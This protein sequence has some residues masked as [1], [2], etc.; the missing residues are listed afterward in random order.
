MDKK[1]RV[2][3]KEN[4]RKYR[5]PSILVGVAFSFSL[6][7]T[8]FIA[9]FNPLI[10]F[11]LVPLLLLP[12]MFA[13]ILLHLGLTYGR[14]ITLKDFAFHFKKYFKSPNSTSFD[15]FKTVAKSFIFYII[16][17][18]IFTFVAYFVCSYIDKENTMKALEIYY[19]F[20]MNDL[21]GDLIIQLGDSYEMFHLFE[22][23]INI[24][25]ITLTNLYIFYKFTLDFLSVYLRLSYPLAHSNFLNA[26]FKLTFSKHKKNILKDFFSL[27]WLYFLLI[28]VG[29]IAG[30]TFALHLSNSITWVCYVSSIFAII[31]SSFYASNIFMNM[32]AIYQKY[33]N[34]FNV[35]SVF[36]TNAYLKRIQNTVELENEE[37]ENLRKL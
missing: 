15:F 24:P 4:R 31:F 29:Y 23:I 37:A 36:V 2:L 8:I 16:F 20:L 21:D 28:L 6:I 17:S 35:A 5:L 1:L 7:L 33:E 12:T 25:A 11:I 27:N 10:S 32:E 14:D 30:I 22:M 3:V 19:N 9:L 18:F 13:L 26:V 34:S